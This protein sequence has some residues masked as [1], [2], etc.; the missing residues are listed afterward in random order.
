MP[1]FKNDVIKP[2]TFLL[3][4]RHQATLDELHVLTQRLSRVIAGLNTLESELLEYQATL[5][6]E[7][8]NY[9]DEDGKTMCI[10]HIWHQISNSL[11]YFLV[12]F[13]LNILQNF[14]IFYI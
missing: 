2:L 11:I 8:P 10:D 4:K 7:F 9:F 5:D 14:L 1:V 3:P 13:V 12:N 6:D